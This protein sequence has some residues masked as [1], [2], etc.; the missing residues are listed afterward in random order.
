MKKLFAITLLLCVV[1]GLS[2]CGNEPPAQPNELQTPQY[3][4]SLAPEMDF[5]AVTEEDIH[6]AGSVKVIGED[7]AEIPLAAEGVAVTPETI[8][9]EDAT[10][11]YNA[12]TLPEKAAFS[13]NGSIGVLSI[14]DL[15]LTVNVYEAADEME[16]M[17]LGAAHFKS[18]S[19]WDGNVGISA[20]NVNFNGTDGYFKYLYKLDAG[21]FLT[22]ET[23]LGSRKY[24]ITKVKTIA[25]DDWSY[26]SRSTDNRITMV[27]CISG[28]PE[29]RLVVQAEET[30]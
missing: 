22:Y 26:L 7:S 19:A 11:T 25:A 8:W 5:E 24:T 23:A 21:D 29:K 30:H 20:H 27:T 10:V 28:Q 1:L 15:Q 12:F 6:S 17:E 4:I 14:P 2:G 18:T 13:E 16:A 9:Q 3:S